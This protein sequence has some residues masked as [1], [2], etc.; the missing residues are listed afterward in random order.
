MAFNHYSKI[1]NIL[2]EQPSGWFIK[3]IQLPTVAKNFRGEI[4]NFDHYYRVFDHLGN[5]IKYCKFQQIDRL[6]AILGLSVEELPIL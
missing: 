3:V 4:V 6:A 1:K 2:N 5:P